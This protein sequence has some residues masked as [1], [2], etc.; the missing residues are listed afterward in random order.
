MSESDKYK[1]FISISVVTFALCSST[2]FVLKGCHE[3]SLVPESSCCCNILY[4]SSSVDIDLDDFFIL[5]GGI[6]IL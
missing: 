4:S 5:L 2:V 6:L 1:S 3:G